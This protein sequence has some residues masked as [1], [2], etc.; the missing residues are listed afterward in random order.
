MLAGCFDCLGESEEDMTGEDLRVDGAPGTVAANAAGC[1]V[2]VK[3]G[4]ATEML[5]VAGVGEDF[6]ELSVTKIVAER[7]LYSNFSSSLR[8]SFAST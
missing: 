8:S 6:P 5:G 2:V 3:E 7:R 4:L 1:A